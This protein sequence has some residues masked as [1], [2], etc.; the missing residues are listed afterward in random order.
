MATFEDIADLGWEP[1]VLG[2]KTRSVRRDAATGLI[3]GLAALPFGL[4][5]LFLFGIFFV[6]FFGAIVGAYAI[7]R[8][9]DALVDINVYGVGREYKWV[10]RAAQLLGGFSIIWPLALTTLFFVG[11]LR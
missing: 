10:A 1:E 9:R 7:S 11:R 5:F 8:G 4:F 2:A 3:V 6:I